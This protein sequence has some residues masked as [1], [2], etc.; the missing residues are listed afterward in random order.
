MLVIIPIKLIFMALLSFVIWIV[1][2]AMLYI[3]IIGLN[4]N[5]PFS[6]TTLAGSIGFLTFTVPLLPGN[7]GTYEAV[8]VAIL[9]I[10]GITPRKALQ[11]PLTDR[12][13]KSFYMLAF[14]LPLLLAEGI[15]FSRLREIEEEVEEYMEEEE[16]R[17]V[18]EN[19]KDE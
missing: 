12:V 19:S 5:V 16:D 6:I 9:S 8:V 2:T 11:V 1:E 7:I 13:I 4:M 3:L 18:M 15:N 17:L 14:G 10:A